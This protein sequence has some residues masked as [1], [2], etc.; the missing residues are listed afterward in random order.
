[1]HAAKTDLGL[2]K[3]VGFHAE[4]FMESY[5]RHARGRPEKCKD[6]SMK[7]TALITHQLKNESNLQS[8]FILGDIQGGSDGFGNACNSSQSSLLRRKNRLPRTIC[9]FRG[10]LSET[11]RIPYLCWLHQFLRASAVMPSAAHV[12]PGSAI[13]CVSIPLHMQSEKGVIRLTAA[14]DPT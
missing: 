9:I 3:D 14:S 13:Q 5:V 1:M 7:R 10:R 8:V 6:N 12:A 4:G 11:S 2:R